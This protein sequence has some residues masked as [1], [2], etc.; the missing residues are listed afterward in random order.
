MPALG[1]FIDPPKEN[2][3]SYTIDASLYLKDLNLRTFEPDNGNFEVEASSETGKKVLEVL[4]SRIGVLMLLGSLASAPSRPPIG[5]I[6]PLIVLNVEGDAFHD[7][8]KQFTGRMLRQVVEHLG[9]SFVRKGVPLTIASNYR[10]SAIYKLDLTK[11]L[12][13]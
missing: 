9:G 6:E 8:M 5:A 7:R 13:N 12:T 1:H 2:T 11:T 4:T 3:M 10:R